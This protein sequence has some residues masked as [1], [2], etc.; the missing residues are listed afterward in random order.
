[1]GIP[2][3]SWNFDACGDIVY[4]ILFPHKKGDLGP[5][6]I[7]HI[8]VVQFW[9]YMLSQLAGNI[10]Q[11][12]LHNTDTTGTLQNCPYYRSVLS[13]EVVQATPPIHEAHLNH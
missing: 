10:L 3:I 4:Q 11:W 12:N 9:T 1:M 6:I 2:R 5:R 7:S 8:L 13:L